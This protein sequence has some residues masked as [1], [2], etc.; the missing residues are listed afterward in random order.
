MFYFIVKSLGSR[1]FEYVMGALLIA[2]AGAVITSQRSL[3]ASVEGRIHD[4]VHRLGKNML[5]VP[6]K[7]DLSRFYELEFDGPSMP[8]S[9][10]ATIQS[11]QVSQHIGYILARLDLE[12]FRQ[13]ERDCLSCLFQVTSFGIFVLRMLVLGAQTGQGKRLWADHMPFREVL[14]ASVE[15]RAARS[16][17]RDIAGRVRNVTCEAPTADA[18][19]PSSVHG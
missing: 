3:S 15:N 19:R 1:W 7:T 13:K 18:R 4:L 6:A 12:S 17:P 8:D 11:S 9:Y 2:P 10:P 5:V 14:H 16:M